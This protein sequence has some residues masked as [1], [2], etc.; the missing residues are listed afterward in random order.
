MINERCRKLE[1]ETE[2][3][4]P[5]YQSSWTDPTGATAAGYQTI[6]GESTAA[7]EEGLKASFAKAHASTS[8][9]HGAAATQAAALAGAASEALQ[10]DPSAA[11]GGLVG[12]QQKE[13]EE[14]MGALQN[15]KLA[16]K[17]M[18]ESGEV[19]ALENFFKKFN[20]VLLD[21]LTLEREQELLEADNFQLRGALE[22][23]LEATSV[24]EHTVGPANPL[25]VVNGR[26][27]I[28]NND[29]RPTAAAVRAVGR[30]N[31]SLPV[32]E[33]NH[34]VETHRARP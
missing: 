12:I 20:K 28:V 10:A 11:S 30:A 27:G 34:M 19:E 16:Q 1:S 17:E 33:G 25:L 32:V 9:P 4:T 26:T 21:K 8:Q 23:F 2:K 14:V 18:L 31:V 22:Q 24:G 3:V 15:S 6:Q 29:V 13:L 7:E 5:F